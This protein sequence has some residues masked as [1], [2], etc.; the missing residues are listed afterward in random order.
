MIPQ[1]SSVPD[2]GNA[3]L[4]DINKT[5]NACTAGG[6]DTSSPESLKEQ[7][8]KKAI[9]RYCSPIPSIGNKTLNFAGVNDTGDVPNNRIP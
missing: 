2:T 6:V 1:L 7:I 4:A 3:S 8:I 9:S 5:G